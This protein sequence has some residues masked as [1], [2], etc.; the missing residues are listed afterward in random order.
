MKCYLRGANEL[1]K[2]VLMIIKK[3]ELTSQHIHIHTQKRE[4]VNEKN[5]W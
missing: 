4:Q 2:Y 1:Q 5:A 3:R